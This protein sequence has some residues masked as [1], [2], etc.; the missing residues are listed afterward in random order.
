L[1]WTPK[2]KK[3]TLEFTATHEVHVDQYPGAGLDQL[4]HVH[5]FG[6]LEAANSNAGWPVLPPYD[7]EGELY[8]GLDGTSGGE[9]LTLLF[10]TGDNSDAE[11][12]LAIEWNYLSLS[13]WKE[14][15]ESPQDG[16]LGFT[17]PGTLKLSLP[18]TPGC[19]ILPLGRYWL[20]AAVAD[21]A[22]S[23]SSMTG[24]H[25][26]A[27]KATFVLNAGG[28]ELDPGGLPA[29]TIKSFDGAAPGLGK[30]LQPYPSFGGRRSPGE[31]EFQLWASERRRHK[32]RA[33]TCW[34]YERLVLERFPEIHQV[35]CV[36]A[37]TEDGAPETFGSVK[38]I[39]VPRVTG[40]KRGIVF[41]P[42]ASA[43]LISDVTEYLQPLAPAAAQ[44]EVV[45]PTYSEVRVRVS[46]R[47]RSSTDLAYYQRRL[48][49]DLNR[50][51][52]PWAFD[53]GAGVTIG[54]RIWTNS[55]VAFLDGLPYVDFTGPVRLFVDGGSSE[56]GGAVAGGAPD[57]V[58]TPAPAHD[59]DPIPDGTTTPE[60]MQGIGYMKIE[61]D[62]E[63]A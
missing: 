59:I 52:A 38:L 57:T 53:E 3:V 37:G 50:F 5:P 9:S 2:L 15:P 41:E 4:Y 6:A 51:L 61:L 16:T 1:P 14:L 23:A 28:A 42:K 26:H 24:V 12:P 10:Q 25:P 49:E 22:S 7:H 30:V 21:G 31:Q 46:V 19:A 48:S 45:S 60:V 55:I 54:G 62:F 29:G 47:F 44:I 17:R 8:I 63:V 32:N 58:L 35:K 40:A 27:G 18:A 20:R 39:I 36:P 34:D 33:V 43:S 11:T 56:R 13:G